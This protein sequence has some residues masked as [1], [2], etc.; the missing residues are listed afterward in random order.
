MKD[1]YYILGIDENA[2][3]EEVKKA[4]RKLSLK[5]HPD[6]NDGD[7]FFEERFKEI[8]E[9][10]E[11]LVDPEKKRIYDFS[12]NSSSEYS[13]SDKQEEYNGSSNNNTSNSYNTNKSHEDNKNNDSTKSYK[14]SP[15]GDLNKK[16]K[17]IKTILF[18]TVVVGFVLFFLFNNTSI[19]NNKTFEETTH[20]AFEWENKGVQNLNNKEY[21]T[22][23]IDFTNSIEEFKKMN[24][25]ILRV[26]GS[27]GYR[28]DC[29][30]AIKDYYGAIN[31]LNEAIK[32]FPWSSLYSKRGLCYYYIG[33]KISACE[34]FSQSADAEK[35]EEPRSYEAEKLIE[36]YC[37]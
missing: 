3:A 19:S 28:A 33:E 20:S 7:K 23:I 8:N 2:S 12:R 1:Y 37:K 11:T 26:G 21:G 5:F 15:S 17:N 34:D 35:N 24:N 10:Y 16:N 14:G 31:D 9:A 29:K 6:K 18:V 36:T 32:I 13:G 30:Y 25:Y 27:Y 22:A 4:Y